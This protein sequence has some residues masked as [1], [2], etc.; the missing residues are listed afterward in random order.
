MQ[1]SDRNR[2]NR[3]SRV[4]SYL[5]LPVLA[6]ALRHLTANLLVWAVRRADA[7]EM[8]LVLLMAGTAMVAVAREHTIW[9]AEERDAMRAPEMVGRWEAIIWVAIISVRSQ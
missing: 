3:E 7:L 5:I 4:V 8:K 2:I 6:A 9:V 1:S